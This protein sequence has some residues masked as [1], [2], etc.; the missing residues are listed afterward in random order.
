M[1]NVPRGVLVCPVCEPS[2]PLPDGPVAALAEN[3]ASEVTL[4]QVEER[5][6]TFRARLAVR[7]IAPSLVYMSQ[8]LSEP[9]R[10]SEL[11]GAADMSSSRFFE[12]FKLATGHA[13]IG[14]FIRMR[15]R[16]ACE[17]LRETDLSVKEV[18]ATLG[19]QDEFY[20]SRLFKSLHRLAPSHYRKQ[21][22]APQ[23]PLNPAPTHRTTSVMDRTGE[24]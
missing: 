9:L 24:L 5:G 17:L 23:S 13:P 19:Y 15:M 12:L 16:R 8:H 22:E 2:F 6:E 7:R 1:N 11:S 18:A 3:R 10:V 14:F 4:K 21:H 20:F